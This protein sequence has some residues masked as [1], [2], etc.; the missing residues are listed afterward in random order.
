MFRPGP[1]GSFQF[2]KFFSAGPYL[3]LS[4]GDLLYPVSLLHVFLRELFGS[5]TLRFF[6]LGQLFCLGPLVPFADNQPFCPGPLCGFSFEGLRFG[7]FFLGCTAI[8]GIDRDE[9]NRQ[10]HD[11]QAEQSICALSHLRLGCGLRAFL[12]GFRQA[13][14]AESG[15]RLRSFFH[16]LDT[17]TSTQELLFIAGDVYPLVGPA[18]GFA[19]G[20]AAQHKVIVSARF[21]PA[22]NRLAQHALGLLGFHPG[23]I[24]HSRKDAIADLQG[25]LHASPARCNHSRE[26]KRPLDRITTIGC[27]ALTSDELTVER[28]HLGDA[29]IGVPT[30]EALFG[31]VQ[32][33]VPTAAAL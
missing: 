12:L 23:R 8:L 6:A 28:E 33:G 27:D 9:R 18:L 5:C 7:L 15:F 14:F 19:Q 32:I 29:R 4:L 21:Q 20:F 10:R 11:H 3:L 31:V 2:C 1:L 26:L 17:P 24:E 25:A 30:L 22:M 16:R 13:S